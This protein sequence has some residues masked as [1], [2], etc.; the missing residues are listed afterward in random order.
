M[1][2]QRRFMEWT[3][4]AVVFL[5]LVFPTD[6]A[7]AVVHFIGLPGRVYDWVLVTALAVTALHLLVTGGR[8][9]S[10]AVVA[11]AFG[12][13]VWAF[14]LNWESLLRGT[15]TGKM[16]LFG[17][18]P[19]LYWLTLLLPGI[20]GAVPSWRRLIGAM[21]FATL[22]AAA[23]GAVALF[24][25]PRLLAFLIE[26]A[27]GD[28]ASYYE[29]SFRL[30]L[31]AGYLLPFLMLAALRVMTTSRRRFAQWAA[32]IALLL[33][34]AILLATQSRTLLGIGVVAFICIGIPDLMRYR[35]SAYIFGF[36]AAV[37]AI[38]VV[39]AA[40]RLDPRLRGVIEDRFGKLFSDPS[41]FLADAY[42]GN[43]DYL[44]AYSGQ[45]LEEHPVLGRGLGT[46]IPRPGGGYAGMQDVTI[47]NHIDK[48]GLTGLSL[49]VVF[50]AF[51][52]YW[53]RR[54]VVTGARRYERPLEF[55]LRRLFVQYFPFILLTCLN[56]DMLYEDPFILVAGIAMGSLMVEG[57]ARGAPAAVPE[58]V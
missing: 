56:V 35:R 24:L 36:A 43:R 55:E 20:G 25:S 17:V 45:S 14:F 28:L 50:I 27:P 3:S 7:A 13:V 12:I 52:Y 19:Y 22:T 34:G 4:L 46:V 41:S 5:A 58:H 54:A 30:P 48:S 18:V 44:Y 2:Y 8:V 33:F 16:V 10:A 39:I 47:L 11:V 40:Q 53:M 32:A 38:G 51:A 37:A 23:L 42:T 26:R 21:M 6:P 15:S 9:A 31:G 1:I 49:F 29:L 57:L